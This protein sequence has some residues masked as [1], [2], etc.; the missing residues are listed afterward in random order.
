[1]P[2]PAPK[3][4]GEIRQ[5]LARYAQAINSRSIEQLR[6]VY[7]TLPAKREGE[8][9]DLFGPD[10]K[11]LSATL[12]I[13]RVEERGDLAEAAFVIS[14]SFRPDRGERLKFTINTT[15]TVKYEGGAWRILTLQEVGS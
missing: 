1:V 12:S 5:L 3:R 15:G 10:V 11:E 2:L 14:L 6:A 13:A 7:P 9:R 8:W 4:E